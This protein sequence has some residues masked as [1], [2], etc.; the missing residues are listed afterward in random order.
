[1]KSG[2]DLPNWSNSKFF[3]IGFCDSPMQASWG[4]E[5]G[6]PR[7]ARGAELYFGRSVERLST[8]FQPNEP[9][10]LTETEA[11]RALR[12][13]HAWGSNANGAGACGTRKSARSSR[14]QAAAPC[15]VSRVTY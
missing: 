7:P 12:R 11:E 2:Y 15:S 10:R 1:M 5:N 9:R 6:A 8:P 4:A 14:R 3:G 13:A